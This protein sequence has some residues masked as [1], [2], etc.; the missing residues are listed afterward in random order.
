MF[1]KFNNLKNPLRFISQAYN[2]QQAKDK[3]QQME[4]IYLL[5]NNKIN[6]KSYFNKQQPI[7]IQ[8]YTL[9]QL[10]QQNTKSLIVTKMFQTIYLFALQTCFYINFNTQNTHHQ[11][12]Q[13][14][15]FVQCIYLYF[16]YHIQKKTEFIFIFAIKQQLKL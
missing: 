1:Y 12:H 2:N 10:I 11:T 6:N 8:Y 3:K 9:Q 5:K 13:I 16:L 15:L 4:F 14:F 7:L